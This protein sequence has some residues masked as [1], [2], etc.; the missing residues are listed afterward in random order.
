MKFLTVLS[1][2][3]AFLL[4][5]QGAEAILYPRKEEVQQ[6]LQ[7]TSQI[8]AED[9]GILVVT[10]DTLFLVKRPKG[11][12]SRR[13]LSVAN[14]DFSGSEPFQVTD[15]DGNLLATMT[16]LLDRTRDS[17]KLLSWVKA[18]PK[19]DYPL[20]YQTPNSTKIVF[21]GTATNLEEAAAK[22]NSIVFQSISNGKPAMSFTDAATGTVN[23]TFG[24]SVSIQQ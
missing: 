1:L 14:I 15:I 4:Q 20:T 8:N 16:I 7:S 21:S 10:Q 18:Q 23:G 11:V 19:G 2:M 24:I 3:A 6:A 9:Y 12:Q 22:S 17:N 13:G 5:S